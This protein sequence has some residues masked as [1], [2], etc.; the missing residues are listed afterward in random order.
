MEK[1]ADFI[2]ITEQ[3]GPYSRNELCHEE[4]SPVMSA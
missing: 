1:E 2:Y 4:F 3:V